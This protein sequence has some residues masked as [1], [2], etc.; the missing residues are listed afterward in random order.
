MSYQAAAAVQMAKPIEALNMLQ[1]L[2]KKFCYFWSLN[3][4]YVLIVI[5]QWMHGSEKT[6][7]KLLLC[8]YVGI[9]M[10]FPCI[11]LKQLSCPPPAPTIHPCWNLQA[12]T[13]E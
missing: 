6:S 9:P 1:M 5:F 11:F 3:N 13:A 10:P 4:T 7:F 8:I 2:M 12:D